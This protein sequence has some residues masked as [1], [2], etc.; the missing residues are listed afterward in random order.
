VS[1]SYLG[2]KDGVYDGTPLVKQFDGNVI[3]VAGNYRASRYYARKSSFADK[4]S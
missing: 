1:S 4:S 2:S 3:Y